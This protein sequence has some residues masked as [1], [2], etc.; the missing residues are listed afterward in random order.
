VDHAALCDEGGGRTCGGSE[1][2]ERIL[3]GEALRRGAMTD[4][5]APSADLPAAKPNFASAKV[6]EPVR[7]GRLRTR[8][9]A[10]A[11]KW[12]HRRIQAAAGAHFDY[13]LHNCGFGLALTRAIPKTLRKAV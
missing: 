5:L 6:S 4:A 3:H 11:W 8:I 10:A 12:A 1:A 7:D 9:G 13:G 2:D